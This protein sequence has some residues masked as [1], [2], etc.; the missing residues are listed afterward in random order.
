M[1]K[2][3]VALIIGAGPAGLTA[4][5]EL[6]QKTDIHP[7]I[8]E[9]DGCVG[10]I[11]RTVNYKGNRIDIGG[12]RF[13]S[14]SD[15]VMNWWNSIL[16][17]QDTLE[18]FPAQKPKKIPSFKETNR[19]MLIRNRLSRIF[20]LKKFFTYPLSLNLETIQGLGITR[21][22]KIGLSYISIK[23]FPLKQE[24]SLEEFFINRFGRELYKTFFKAYTEKL[25]GVP[26]SKIQAHWGAQRIKGLSMR[27][28][29]TH[30]IASLWSNKNINQK[31]IETSL[32]EKFLY[33]KHGPGQMWEAVAEKIQKQGGEIYFHHNV[34]KL[35]FTKNTIQKIIAKDTQTNTEK[36]F[37]VDYVFSSM[38]VK[39]LIH[40]MGKY[41]PKEITS[42]AQKLHYRDFMTVGLLCKKM[43]MATK[44][45]KKH[46][47][48]DT[49]IYIQ[50]PQVKLGRVQ[51]FNN[52]SPYM[53]KNPESTAW[54]GL[55]YFVTKGDDLWTMPDKDFIN[56]ASK[57]LSSTGLINTDDILDSVV[58]R[59]EKAYPSYVGEGYNRFHELRT[60]TDSIENLFLIGRNGMHQYNNQDHS[61][62]S[63]MEA[64][65]NI[66]H[67]VKT[68]D[69]IW[70]VNAEKKY[71]EKK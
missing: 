68:K 39:H 71:H 18:T 53:V 45:Y 49:W 34:S 67:N 52:W 63:A 48:P 54:I 43:G 46:I 20:F 25:W 16:P 21:I 70:N 10:G 14:K 44:I 2:K 36:E 61:M 23:I 8:L 47:T 3:K 59:M 5:Y 7:I 29:L 33:P 41:A 12:H 57:E 27:K 56:F 42:I 9:K 40:S 51:I 15:I 38:P 58:I 4:A 13:F 66:I 28:A 26:C 69:N 11:S 60:F 32:I 55:E 1:Q 62:L 6:L 24:K 30:A 31:N 37:S 65:Q 19:A 35:L 22:I 17:F 64:V 50:E